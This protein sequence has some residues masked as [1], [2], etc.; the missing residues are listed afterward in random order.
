[1]SSETKREWASARIAAALA[2]R[3]VTIDRAVDAIADELDREAE[4][5]AAWEAK[6][7]GLLDVLVANAGFSEEYLVVM[8]ARGL[9]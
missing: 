3:E 7:Q 8:R 4:R 1:M 2:H 9:L 6:T 5:R